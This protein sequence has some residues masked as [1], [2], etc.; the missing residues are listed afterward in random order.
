MSA[1]LIGE[2]PRPVGYGK[3]AREK[4]GYERARMS[5]EGEEEGDRAPDG[6]NKRER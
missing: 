2:P 3:G 5:T 6:F 4:D 1:S